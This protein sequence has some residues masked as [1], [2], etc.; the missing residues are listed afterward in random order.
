MPLSGISD[1]TVLRLILNTLPPKYPAST[2]S[3]KIEFRTHCLFT[4]MGIH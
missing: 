3:H 1:C 2:I 4:F